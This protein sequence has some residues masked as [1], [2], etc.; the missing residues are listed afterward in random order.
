MNKYVF[1]YEEKHHIICVDGVD[2]EVPQRT[3]AIEEKLKEHDRKI[4][5]M[6]EYEG[7]M[8]LLSILF[9]KEQAEQM[10]PDKE[11]TNLDK[12]AKCVH[13]SISLYMSEINIIKSEKAKQAL[14]QLKPVIK[15]VEKIGDTALKVSKKGKK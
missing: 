11:N 6:S 15:S 9:G 8:N 12:L 2:Y 14:E 13:Y 4:P 7:N 1:E 3:A 10:F 5:E